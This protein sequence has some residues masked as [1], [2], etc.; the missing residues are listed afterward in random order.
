[1]PLMADLSI[2]THNQATPESPNDT[3]TTWRAVTHLRQVVD[4]LVLPA[5]RDERAHGRPDVPAPLRDRPQKLAACTRE[6]QSPW[7]NDR[8]ARTFATRPCSY[9]SAQ[10]HHG[11]RTCRRM[12]EVKFSSGEARRVQGTACGCARAYPERSRQRCSRPAA[13]VSV[14]AAR[15]PGQPAAE[16]QMP[17]SCVTQGDAALMSSRWALFKD[18]PG[19]VHAYGFIMQ[20]TANTAERAVQ[21]R[22]RDSVES[23]PGH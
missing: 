9:L 19:L 3:R 8:S 10:G 23:A 4:P 16:L 17:Y 12:P 6:A 11:C 13:L 14:G 5:H 18:W 7:A 2:W 15:T 20:G 1:V 22:A 21:R